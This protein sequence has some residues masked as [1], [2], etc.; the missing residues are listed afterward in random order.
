MDERHRR[1][2]QS[3][4]KR[5]G[6]EIISGGIDY[7]EAIDYSAEEYYELLLSEKLDIELID[8]QL[9]G[10]EAPSDSHGEANRRIPAITAMRTKVKRAIRSCRWKR[11]ATTRMKTT[12]IP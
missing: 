10:Q 12:N 7:P 3:D 4:V 9:E 6:L 1:S 11:I 5:D 8:G 2:H